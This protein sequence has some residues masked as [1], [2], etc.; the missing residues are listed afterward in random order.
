MAGATKYK[1]AEA[2]R[3]TG[4]SPSTLRLW[5]LQGLIEPERTQG[6]QRCYR[7]HHLD[8][9]KRIRWQR[10]EQG[11][12]P[13]AIKASL[14]NDAPS[15]ANRPDADPVGKRV[16]SLR[17]AQGK[18][19]ATIAGEAGIAVSALSTFERTSQG[20]SV[21][22]LHDL[23]TALGTSV[24]ALSG[25]TGENARHLV[26][27]GAWQSWPQTMPGVTVQLLAEGRNQMDCHRF[28]LA[29][30][31]SSEGAYKHE[32]EEFIHV[33]SG[34]LQI[35]LGTEEYQV[36]NPGDSLYF[37][38]SIHHSWKNT[39]AGETILLWVNTPPT[40]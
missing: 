14:E 21:R 19:L 4:V 20:L 9:L 40:F 38:S 23:A 15:V 13:A 17:Q 3:L 39:F 8:Q 16:R 33:L 24:S 18:T 2:A 6:G 1:V 10:A 30:G 32:G 31:A 28:V 5:E 27:S 36:L 34:Q 26:R 22:A 7:D 35:A 37:K 29:A 12:N 11:L 25:N